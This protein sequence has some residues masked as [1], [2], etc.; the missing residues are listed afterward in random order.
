MC[1]QCPALG[2]SSSP[3]IVL[4]IVPRE[5]DAADPCALLRQFAYDSPTLVGTAVVDEDNLE[6]AA[7]HPQN[8]VQSLDSFRERRHGVKDRHPN[9]PL[10]LP[11]RPTVERIGPGTPSPVTVRSP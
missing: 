5:T 8:T 3:D 1:A 10:P 7:A 11:A 4:A 6:T 2:N 9:R